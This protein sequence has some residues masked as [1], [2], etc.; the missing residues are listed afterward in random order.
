MPNI[1]RRPEKLRMIAA[2]HIGPE[3]CAKVLCGGFNVA[4]KLV[5]IKDTL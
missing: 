2:A 4:K 5:S 3:K 1:L